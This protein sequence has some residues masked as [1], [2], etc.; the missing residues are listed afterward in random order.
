MERKLLVLDNEEKTYIR[1]DKFC[2]VFFDSYGD[3]HAF[4]IT[5][6]MLSASS[7]YI[8]YNGNSMD[9]IEDIFMNSEQF[10]VDWEDLF[11]FLKGEEFYCAKK[12]MYNLAFNLK[13]IRECLE[14]FKTYFIDQNK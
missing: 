1:H 13:N 8:D 4:N 7:R 6:I 11:D 14:D 3:T 9:E 10:K 2:R 5:E 12:E